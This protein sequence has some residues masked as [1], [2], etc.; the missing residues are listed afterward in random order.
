MSQQIKEKPKTQVVWRGLIGFLVFLAGIGLAVIGGIISP[1]NGT[2]ILILVI[3]GIIVGFI[4]ITAREAIPMMIAAIALIVVGA[5]GGG[6]QPLDDVIG[7]LGTTLND[8]VT[9]FSQFMAPAA[10]IA[11]VRAL[12]SFGFPGD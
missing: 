8:M 9:Y 3:L 6:F 1:D 7:N 11:A 12:L 4:N 2:I 10:V 5:V